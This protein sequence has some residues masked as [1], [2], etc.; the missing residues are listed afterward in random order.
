MKELL[1]KLVDSDVDSI[2]A[3]AKSRQQTPDEIVRQALEAGLRALRN[4]DAAGVVRPAQPMTKETLEAGF[5]IWKDSPDV[6]KDGLEY[7]LMVR[8]EWD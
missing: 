6:P 5:G 2:A 8:A 1:V 7:Q 3:I 4:E